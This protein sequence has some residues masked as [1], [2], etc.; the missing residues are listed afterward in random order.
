MEFKRLLKICC[1]AALVAFLFVGLGP[2]AWQPRSG[3]GWQFDHFAG[4]FVLTL[5]FCVAWPRPF[6]VGGGLIVFAALLEA[7]QAI[8]PDRDS[9][10]F[11]VI[12]SAAGVLAAALVAD[13]F[14]RARRQFQAKR[15]ETPKL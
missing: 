4:Y 15:V 11:A 1:V 14:I 5:M 13:L 10:I 12:Y 9:N 2:S 8:P 6:V 7:L 3:I